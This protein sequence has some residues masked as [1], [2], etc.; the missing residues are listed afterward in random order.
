M[1][2]SNG[3]GFAGKKSTEIDAGTVEVDGNQTSSETCANS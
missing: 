3:N 2:D 1:I